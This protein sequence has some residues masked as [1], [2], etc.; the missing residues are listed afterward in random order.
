MPDGIVEERIIFASDDLQ[1]AA[2]LAYPD[3]MTPERA[4]LLCSPHPHFAGNMD[5]NVVCAIARKLATHSVTLRFDYRGVGDSQI[6]LRSGLS[7]FDYWSKIEEARDY[8]DAVRDVSAAACALAGASGALNIPLS[9]VGYSFG[10]ATGLL[11][12]RSKDDVRNMVAIAPP[13][14]K[15]SFDF[16]S[17]CSKPCLC[18]IGKGDFLYSSEKAEELRRTLPSNAIV[19]ILET[20]DHFFRG[21]EDLVAERVDEFVRDNVIV[22]SEETSDAI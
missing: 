2:V 4:V 13:L 8:S 7:V 1:L 6:N 12:G 17:D 15:V 16:M 19:E 5:N 21:D 9:V 22:S 3:G 14:G 10:T 18:L 20:A 11:Y